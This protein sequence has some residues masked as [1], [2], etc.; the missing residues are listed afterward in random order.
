MKEYK[1]VRY[2][3]CPLVEVT[4]QIN[5]PTILSIDVDPP[6]AF[7]DVIRDKFPI[8][9]QQVQHENQLTINVNNNTAIPFVQK[10]NER[11][12]HVFI[13][14]DGKWRIML[15]SNMIAFSTLEYR[16]WED[17]TAKFI[18]PLKAMIK[19]YHPAFCERIGLRYVDAFIKEDL[20]LGDKNWSEL[21]APHICGCLGYQ[22]D[23]VH[24][25]NSVVNSDIRKDNV[26][27]KVNAGL[28]TI[29][30]QDDKGLRESFVLN[31]DYYA[32]GKYST[33]MLSEI[34]AKLHDESHIFFRDSIT[35]TL[36]KAMR[37]V[38]L[39]E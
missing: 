20:G 30:K 8:Y 29:D 25:R 14:K 7:Q 37:P 4:Y 38:D 33:K 26:N 22:S 10:Q 5:F 15:S 23:G 39:G 13:S 21:L 36:H 9:Q 28:G 35:N 6:A 31:C 18:T 2:E 19:I 17:M 12:I 16:Q 34:A 27:I 11:K 3:N 24:V 1:R 32:N